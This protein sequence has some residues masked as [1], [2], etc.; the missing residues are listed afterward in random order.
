M[1]LLIPEVSSHPASGEHIIHIKKSARI[2]AAVLTFP[3]IEGAFIAIFSSLP[4]G[5]F[6]RMDPVHHKIAGGIR[7]GEQKEREHEHFGIPEDSTFIDL[8]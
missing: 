4:P 7:L 3:G 1:H 2:I 5:S 8:P 6:K